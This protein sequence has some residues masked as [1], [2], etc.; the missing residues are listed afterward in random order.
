MNCVKDCNDILVEIY[1]AVIINRS[2]KDNYHAFNKMKK[3][4]ALM[5]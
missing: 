3:M 5:G 4:Q 2:A 1:A